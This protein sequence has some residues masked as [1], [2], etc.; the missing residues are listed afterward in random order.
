MVQYR[1]EPEEL[2]LGLHLISE[3]ILTSCLTSSERVV[4]F[5]SFG[6]VWFSG[7]TTV[8]DLL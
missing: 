4:N 5:V 1:S 7:F 2:L 6:S 8:K 3:I